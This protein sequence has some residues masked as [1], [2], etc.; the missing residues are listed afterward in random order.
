MREKIGALRPHVAAAY[1]RATAPP[2]YRPREPKLCP[3][4]RTGIVNH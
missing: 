4:K 2:E 1:S 3:L